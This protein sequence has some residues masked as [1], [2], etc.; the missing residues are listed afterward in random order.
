[1]RLDVTDATHRKKYKLVNVCEY[2]HTFFYTY[3]A[4]VEKKY[5]GL[6]EMK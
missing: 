6:R 1:V 4:S 5:L 2:L 3:Y